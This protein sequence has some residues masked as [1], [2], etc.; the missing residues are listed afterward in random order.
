[1]EIHLSEPKACAPWSQKLSLLHSTIKFELRMA[2]T[3]GFFAIEEGGKP[4]GPG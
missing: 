4:L 3:N 2:E 1:M